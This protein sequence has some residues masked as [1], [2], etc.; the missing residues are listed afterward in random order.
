MFSALHGLAQSSDYTVQTA[1][2]A[3]LDWGAQAK[4]FSEYRWQSTRDQLLDS[5]VGSTIRIDALPIAANRIQVT[6]DRRAVWSTR[7]SL[8]DGSSPDGVVNI[9]IPAERRNG[10]VG[11]TRFGA[12]RVSFLELSI[13]DVS[14]RLAM[15]V[16]GR[17]Q[18]NVVGRIRELVVDAAN[19]RVALTVDVITWSRPSEQVEPA[20]VGTQRGSIRSQMASGQF[21]EATRAIRELQRLVPGDAELRQWLDDMTIVGRWSVTHDHGVEGIVGSLFGEKSGC[22]GSIVLRKAF[23]EFRGSAHDAVWSLQEIG[24]PT[25][26]FPIKGFTVSSRGGQKFRFLT[27]TSTT[28][29]IV[30]A[31][32]RARSMR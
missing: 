28:N 9:S 27:E 30:D 2:G 3:I 19:E 1:I 25:A 18:I 29:E 4:D 26:N 11:T 7:A 8:A 10:I 5:L 14:D 6:A 20:H 17:A 13:A 22:S 32:G 16:T 31:V 21:D 12:G 24:G 23:L 15:E